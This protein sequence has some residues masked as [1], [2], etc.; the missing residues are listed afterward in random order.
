MKNQTGLPIASG[1][2]LIHVSAPGVGEK[3]LKFFCVLRPT[4]L[5]AL[6]TN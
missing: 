6:S 5:D 2:Y 4:D 1:V 3:T